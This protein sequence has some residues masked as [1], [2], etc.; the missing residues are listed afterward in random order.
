MEKISFVDL[1]MEAKY[2]LNHTKS[3]VFI[4]INVPLFFNLF[5]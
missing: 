1:I 4:K 3:I 2:P 5:L